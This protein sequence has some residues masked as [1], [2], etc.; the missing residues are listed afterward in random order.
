MKQE[1]KQ[2]KLPIKVFEVGVLIRG[3]FH[4]GKCCFTSSDPLEAGN[5]IK[6][7]ACIP[8]HPVGRWREEGSC[9]AKSHTDISF[10]L[11]SHSACSQPLLGVGVQDMGAHISLA[12]LPLSCYRILRRL[13]TEELLWVNICPE[14]QKGKCACTTRHKWHRPASSY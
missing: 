7:N 8:E 10:P 9:S 12:R 13:P 14:G 3:K 6:R 5:T 4:V 2:G 11:W 1:Q